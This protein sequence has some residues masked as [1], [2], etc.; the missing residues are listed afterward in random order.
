M[1]NIQ[2]N[3]DYNKTKITSHIIHREAMS[4]QESLYE[5]NI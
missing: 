4:V 3:K 1:D 5:Y 2:Q